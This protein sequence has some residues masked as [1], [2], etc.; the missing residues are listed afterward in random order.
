MPVADTIAHKDMHCMQ[1][2]NHCVPQPSDMQLAHKTHRGTET[3]AH[4]HSAIHT[5]HP[6]CTHATLFKQ[7]TYPPLWMLS[8]AT[9][10]RLKC[11]NHKIQL[12]PVHGSLHIAIHALQVLTLLRTYCCLQG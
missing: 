1:A 3:H 10:Q 7:T 4:S 2:L 12:P 5:Q 9:A 11:L 8:T 6:A